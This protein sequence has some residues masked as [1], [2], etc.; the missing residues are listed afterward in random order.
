MNRSK[1]SNKILKKMDSGFITVDQ[2]I[3]RHCNMMY[4]RASGQNRS[5]Q[6][7]HKLQLIETIK[8]FTENGKILLI[9]GG[10]DCDGSQYEGKTRVLNATFVEVNAFI[11]DAENWA[12]GS[13]YFDFD[14]PSNDENYIRS[15]RDLVLEAFENGHQH[16]I[17]T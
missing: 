17:Y 9:E 10:C 1:I 5:D 11:Q 12:D 2:A 16:I 8:K 7:A 4:F 15:S 3:D 6:L 13:I 14:F